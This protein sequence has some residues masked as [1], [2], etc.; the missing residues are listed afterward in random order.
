MI[1]RLVYD[2]KSR[3]IIMAQEATGTVTTTMHE[4]EEFK[5]EEA[6]LKRIDELGLVSVL[7]ND[8]EH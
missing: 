6:M 2:K 7:I 1:Y 8:S 5:T 4:M 3:E